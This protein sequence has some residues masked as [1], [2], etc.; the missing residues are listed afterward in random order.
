MGCFVTEVSQKTLYRFRLFDRNIKLIDEGIALQK[1]QSFQFIN[2]N[3]FAT[4]PG[5]DVI[6]FDFV[7]GCIFK[8]QFVI[9]QIKDPIFIGVFQL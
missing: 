3:E 7:G 6:H 9:N 2:P 5:F 8:N 1:F 4:Q